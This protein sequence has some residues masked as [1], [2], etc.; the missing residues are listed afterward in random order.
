MVKLSRTS[1]AFFALAG[2]LS[3][4]LL[5]TKGAGSWTTFLAAAGFLATARVTGFFAGGV[6][7][8]ATAG[9]LFLAGF[10]VAGAAGLTGCGRTAGLDAGD[11]VLT[12]AVEVTAGATDSAV[13]GLLVS[14]GMI[15]PLFLLN[16]INSIFN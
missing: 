2:L 6:T 1:L 4:L 12:A 3:L 9:G 15:N 13:A 5:A 10:A 8:L 7:A 14:F 16:G 11:G